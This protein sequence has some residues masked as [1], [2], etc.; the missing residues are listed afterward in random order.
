MF[1]TK[2]RNISSLC[3]ECCTHFSF[4]FKSCLGLH[5]KNKIQTIHPIRMA[6]ESIHPVISPT[7]NPVVS[8]EYSNSLQWCSSILNNVLWC[9]CGCCIP[10][11]VCVCPVTYSPGPM[12][13][14]AL[15]L[16]VTTELGGRSLSVWCVSDVLILILSS[17]TLL[18]NW[19]S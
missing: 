6:M 11:C 2:S 14:Y 13:V 3:Y 10:V 15:T 19:S 18:L 12:M 5:N 8:A 17:T 9:S 1:C 4:M 16:N 7:S